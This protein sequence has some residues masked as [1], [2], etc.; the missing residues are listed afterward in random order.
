[1]HAYV[2]CRYD[3]ARARRACAAAAAAAAPPPPPPPPPPTVWPPACDMHCASHRM[4][5]VAGAYMY[6]CLLRGAMV[7]RRPR[8][9]APPCVHASRASRIDRR[10]I[11][12]MHR[13]GGCM[14]RCYAAA[15]APPPLP[16]IRCYSLLYSRTLRYSIRVRRCRRRRRRLQRARA[17]RAWRRRRAAAAAAGPKG[18]ARQ[19]GILASTMYN[20]FMTITAR[21][22][23]VGSRSPIGK[24]S[25]RAA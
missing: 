19:T 7:M 23:P 17:P 2:G 24:I 10:R 15:A 12:C 16:P 4:A 9:R 22:S 25:L 18:H 1:V 11:V 5:C 20:M 8:A 3:R 14:M 21:S 13:M 6:A